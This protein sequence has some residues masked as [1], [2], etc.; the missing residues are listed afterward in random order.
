[1]YG[2]RRKFMSVNDSA[3]FAISMEESRRVRGR[4]TRNAMNTQRNGGVKTFA[5]K[6][7]SCHIDSWLEMLY[8]MQARCTDGGSQDV[9]NFVEF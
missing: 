9:G 4:R 7:N 3:R 5:W 6:K 2:N 8:W 1:M